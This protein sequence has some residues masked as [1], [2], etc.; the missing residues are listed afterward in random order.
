[1]SFFKKLFSSSP[2][3]ERSN[4]LLIYLDADLKK[5][6]EVRDM[7]VRE[8]ELESNFDEDQFLY[9]MVLNKKLS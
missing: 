4:A 2:P 1:M 7:T 9:L 8:Y 6:I 3:K 5:S